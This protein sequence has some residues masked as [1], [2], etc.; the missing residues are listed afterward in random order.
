M[1]Q[2]L[3]AV[4]RGGPSSE[5]E[6][7][8]KSGAQV[9]QH[10]PEHYDRRDVFISKDG[11]WHLGGVAVTPHKALYGAHVAFNAMHGEYGED[12]KVQKIL[13]Q[14]DIPYTG[15]DTIASAVAINKHV[16]K[17]RYRSAGLRTPRHMLLKFSDDFDKEAREIFFNFHMP[18]VIKPVSMG[19][20]VGIR[21]AMR[22]DQIVPALEE[23]ARLS[24]Q[25]MVEEFI[26]GR[27]ATC[28][29]VENFRGE[30]HYTPL[31][32]EIIFPKHKDH[33][34]YESKYSTTDGALE[35]CPPSFGEEIKREISRMAQEAHKILGLRHYS[36]SDFRINRA[37][38]VYILETNTLP[39]LTSESLLPKSL[40]AV[41]C[42]FPQFLDHLVTLALA[43]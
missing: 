30:S 6:V 12:G 7:S 27:E 5:Y 3:V 42:T 16:S 15:S 9:L 22:L 41:G 29:V 1:S 4:L 25:I 36:R 38:K 31:P 35:I 39:G 28:G 34:D 10:L 19:S 13:E 21:V 8:L 32:V 20:S 2:T 11:Q 14:L 24:S 43:R 26:D 17:D 18:V 23:I 33:F 40:A 37:G